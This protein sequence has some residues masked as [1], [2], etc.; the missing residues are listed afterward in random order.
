[1]AELDLEF[2]KNL[3][4]LGIDIVG[5]KIMLS[6]IGVPALDETENGVGVGVIGIGDP[7]AQND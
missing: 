5:D 2:A 1:M 6:P 4:P 3:F 7:P